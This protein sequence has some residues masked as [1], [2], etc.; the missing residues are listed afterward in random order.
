[1]THSRLSNA[2]KSFKKALDDK[3]G[4]DEPINALAKVE[5][6]IV[7]DLRSVVASDVSLVL[8]DLTNEE[9]EQI[10]KV[11]IQENIGSIS[12]IALV[13]QSRAD[14]VF[15]T[16]DLEAVDQYFNRLG[17]LFHQVDHVILPPNII[18]KAE[19][20]K[21][22]FETEEKELK[23]NKLELLMSLLYE[24]GVFPNKD[25][26]VVQGVNT[27]DM[28]REGSY[29]YIEIPKLNKTVLIHLGYKQ[30]T[31]IVEGIHP[32]DS[33][34]DNS[35]DE[36][37][38]HLGAEKITFNENKVGEWKAKIEEALTNT[39]KLEEVDIERFDQRQQYIYE[40]KNKYPT[41]KDFISLSYDNRRALNIRGRKLAYLTSIICGQGHGLD[42]YGRNED[43]IVL[44]SYIYPEDPELQQQFQKENKRN[45]A[46]EWDREKLIAK[47]KEMYPTA[48]EF[49][50]AFNDFASK[51][52]TVYGIG[53]LSIRS[54]I[55][56][57]NSSRNYKFSDH[58]MIARAIYGEGYEYIDCELWGKKEWIERIK[59]MFPTPESLMSLK[60]KAFA[61]I[62]VHRFKFHQ[63]GE[64]ITGIQD[65]T[66]QLEVLDVAFIAREVY[67]EGHEV[68]D[69]HFWNIE[70]WK[71][72]VK[73]LWPAPK[74]WMAMTVADKIAVDFFGTKI[75]A[76]GAKFGMSGSLP[77][78]NPE[79]FA[80]LGQ[81]IYGL[82]HRVIDHVL[83]D[84]ERWIGE[85]LLQEE[86]PA[87]REEFMKLPGAKLRKV[88]ICGRRIKY[89]TKKIL[90]GK[91]WDPEDTKEHREQLADAI[92]S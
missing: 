70:R 55:L 48:Q 69:V 65:F 79:N 88:K 25:I 28:Y 71:K 76:L 60:T 86:I 83:W 3:P 39:K 92:Y 52:K 80:E 90:G 14:R 54:K 58:A 16:E 12:D 23:E 43:F 42:S 72:E 13:I 50:N 19:D 46:K 61:K 87:T 15:R 1:M 36:L 20:P 67:G 73:K 26:S 45:E 4:T 62:Q 85:L 35:K 41:F 40:I 89:I 75:T 37:H 64:V 59:E 22:K 6:M 68:I 78:T 18:K 77:G 2:L 31:Y 74:D 57:K 44:A 30:A 81:R 27:P 11:L 47:I 51:K 84:P 10:D 53:K 91:K 38:D 17:V 8:D 9:K 33:M 63:I 82:G 24:M 34:F 5:N 56:S 66:N 49:W 21:K 32:R 29:F 7:Q